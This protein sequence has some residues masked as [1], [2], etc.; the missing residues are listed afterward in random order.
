MH[1]DLL[2]QEYQENEPALT[3]KGGELNQTVSLY[4][5]KNTTVHIQGKINAVTLGNS[6][7]RL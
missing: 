2:L 6:T 3:V 7:N 4:G 5:C 1:T